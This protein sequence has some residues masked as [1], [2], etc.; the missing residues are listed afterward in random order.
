MSSK[1]HLH[2]SQVEAEHFTLC[3]DSMCN[4][5]LVLNLFTG[6]V[7]DIGSCLYERVQL[8]HF[9]GDGYWLI[10]MSE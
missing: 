7:M 3:S 4:D 9:I 10:A 1:P 5:A 2:A 8:I 6:S